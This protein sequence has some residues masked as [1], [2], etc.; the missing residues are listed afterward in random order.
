[1][2]PS[3]QIC[4]KHLCESEC[5]NARRIH[6][7][8]VPLERRKNGDQ[9]KKSK[10]QRREIGRRIAVQIMSKNHRHTGAKQKR[11]IQEKELI[12]TPFFEGVH[13]K[14]LVFGALILSMLA[15]C[16]GGGGGDTGT[17]GEGTNTV[18]CTKPTEQ[19]TDL[20][21]TGWASNIEYSALPKLQNVTV[22]GEAGTIKFKSCSFVKKLTITGKTNTILFDAS[23]DVEEVVFE[24]NTWANTVELSKN[25][26]A[27]VLDLGNANTVTRKN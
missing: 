5:L 17:A 15:A 27:T 1:M 24:V 20:N 13:M 23:S 10:A 21:L 4:V 22:S 14:K 16:G 7:Q 8:N 19:G 2:R 26:P 9:S 12:W 25:S 3:V 11:A 6:A 18:K